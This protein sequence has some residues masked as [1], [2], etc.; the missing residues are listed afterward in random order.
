V[1]IT[2]Y[3][4]HQIFQWYE[5]AMGPERAA[6]MMQL[7]PPVG[8]GDVATKADLVALEHRL[9]A[10]ADRLD[11]RIDRQDGRFEQIEGRFEKIDG[12]FEQIEGRFE[13]IHGRFER[14]EGRM[15]LIAARNLRT[16]VLAML[17]GN[18]TLV[19]AV[20]AVAQLG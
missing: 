11:A 17:A 9:L 16:M 3:E 4:R 12:R 10:R 7:L 14:L 8:W 6:I 2:E 13:Q 15:E 20:V 5:E 1:S 18:A 19:G